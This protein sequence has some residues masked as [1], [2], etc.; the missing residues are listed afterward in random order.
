MGQK[1]NQPVAARRPQ[2]GR[3]VGAKKPA[4]CFCIFANSST[5]MAQQVRSLLLISLAIAALQSAILSNCQNQLQ[6][7]DGAGQRSSPQP[8]GAQPTGTTRCNHRQHDGQHSPD[9]HLRIQ[10]QRRQRQFNHRAG[11][12][13]AALTAPAQPDQSQNQSG[14][15]Q[16]IGQPEEFSLALGGAQQAPSRSG[17]SAYQLVDEKAA[18]SDSTTAVPTTTTAAAT[19]ARREQFDTVSTTPTLA[20]DSIGSPVAPQP[21]ATTSPGLLRASQPQVA[22]TEPTGSG[23]AQLAAGRRMEASDGSQPAGGH[24]SQF[25]LRASGEEQFERPTGGGSSSGLHSISSSPSSVSIITPITSPLQ[26]QQQQQSSSSSM[27]KPILVLGSPIGESD[28]SNKPNELQQSEQPVRPAGG[29]LQ[30][31]S[32]RSEK[33]PAEQQVAPGAEGRPHQATISN[34]TSGGQPADERMTGPTLVYSDGH[35][36][37]S[38][39]QQQ[40]ADVSAPEVAAS[41]PPPPALAPRL[42][43]A[44]PSAPSAAVLGNSPRR[45]SLPPPVNQANAASG[46]RSP[47]SASGPLVGQPTTLASTL[48]PPV[49]GAGFLSL[50]QQQAATGAAAGAAPNFYQSSPPYA[51]GQL[52]GGASLGPLLASKPSFVVAAQQQPVGTAAPASSSLAGYQSRRPLNI[53]RVERR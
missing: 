17:G 51:G 39:A 49:N 20:A 18:P 50:G 4:R 27:M 15:N 7:A 40:E 29:F 21:P 13:S 38:V 28:Y 34:A 46:F 43:Q 33:A 30:Q 25:Q 5:A 8:A 1:S 11:E 42:F 52:L 47:M 41:G 26:Q 9:E 12:L 37:S 22:P 35:L 53:T 3:A 16:V 45:P 48:Q 24:F 32:A 36:L 2:V 44:P 31:H 6:R 10:Q 19:G 14:S 23:R